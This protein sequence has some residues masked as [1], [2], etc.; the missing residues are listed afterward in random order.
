MPKV[1]PV[2]S[3]NTLTRTLTGSA[4]FTR[5][6]R[7]EVRHELGEVEFSVSLSPGLSQP[8][9][10]GVRDLVAARRTRPADNELA[11]VL[12]ALLLARL[13]LEEFEVEL[14]DDV[15]PD[16]PVLPV[17]V[18]LVVRVPTKKKT[19]KRKKSKTKNSKTRL[20]SKN[21]T[22]KKTKKTR[23]DFSKMSEA[24]RRTAAR[25]E[26]ERLRSRR[27]REDKKPPGVRMGR[28]GYT[29]KIF[30][31]ESEREVWRATA[32]GAALMRELDRVWGKTVLDRA[33]LVAHLKAKGLKTL[34]G[35]PITR[36]MMTDLLAHLDRLRLDAE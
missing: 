4:C 12:E 16:N 23:P 25:R 15:D 7:G 13:N 10:E 1:I 9:V 33:A 28:P 2:A 17:T 35:R 29:E 11:A 36:N 30:D 24:E 18:T 31:P 34:S 8:F 22:K 26:E 20:R 6:E 19:A 27:R 32:A 14:E 5:I 3:V 21:E